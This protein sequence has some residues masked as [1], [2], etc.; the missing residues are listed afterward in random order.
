MQFVKPTYLSYFEPALLHSA[1]SSARLCRCLE[2]FL[3]FYF[4][5]PHRVRSAPH[6]PYHHPAPLQAILAIP[7][8][9]AAS[10][11]PSP[12]HA[13]VVSQ[14]RPFNTL[15]KPPSSNTQSPRYLEK[16][17]QKCCKSQI[18][19]FFLCDQLCRY[20]KWGWAKYLTDRS[21]AKWSRGK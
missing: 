6:R 14:P 1:G 16:K 4:S 18:T 12:T 10:R 9:E 20:S 13:A 17:N 8:P 15:A 3:S 7:P 5:A 2:Y 19:T 21:Q 11:M